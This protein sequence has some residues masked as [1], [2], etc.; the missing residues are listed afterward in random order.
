MS[1]RNTLQEKWSDSWFSELH[2]DSKYLFLYLIDN[3]DIAGFVEYSPKK[4]AYD[5]GL[6]A[7]EIRGALEGLGRGLAGA[8]DGSVYFIKNF[9]KHQNNFPLNPL[10]NAHYGIFKRF[11]YYSNKFNNIKIIKI[12]R[13]ATEGLKSPTGKSNSK[14]NSKFLY[15]IDKLDSISDLKELYYLVENI[16]NNDISEI[17]QTKSEDRNKVIEKPKSENNHLPDNLF[18]NEDDEADDNSDIAITKKLNDK[19][20]NLADNKSYKQTI[21]PL[22]E[23]TEAI[24]ILIKNNELNQTLFF[25][26]L[27]QCKNT[28]ANFN[29]A[30]LDF[31]FWFRNQ[32]TNYKKLLNGSFEWDKKNNDKPEQKKELTDFEKQL[33][34]IQSNLI[35]G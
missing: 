22:P 27:E 18:Q 11:F 15:F 24:R 2:K 19:Y 13:G 33:I 16:R 28:I 35:K 25:E 20:S 17:E 10:N 4:W 1:Y 7:E 23:T 6:T 32:A 8:L 31:N 30:P 9:C 14:S 12:I 26:K 34:E 3:C 29:N 21:Y 5:T